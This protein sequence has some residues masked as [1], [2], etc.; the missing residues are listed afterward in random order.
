MIEERQPD[1]QRD[2]PHTHR[3]RRLQRVVQTDVELSVGPRAGTG[4]SASLNHLANAKS[5][6]I[7]GNDTT[8]APTALLQS[9][10]R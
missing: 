9:V 6:A 2:E 10:D 1:E 7:V 5:A 8:I 4:Y 3:K